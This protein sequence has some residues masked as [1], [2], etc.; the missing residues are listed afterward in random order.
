MMDMM[1]LNLLFEN[2][3]KLKRKKGFSRNFVGKLIRKWNEIFSTNNK[4]FLQTYIDLSLRPTVQY[5][6]TQKK[7]QMF[8]MLCVNLFYF[9]HGIHITVHIYLH[10][11]TL[12]LNIHM[13]VCMY[14]CMNVCTPTCNT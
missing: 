12:N 13:Y 6:S 14:V 4:Y 5:H 8:T 11:I 1:K 9:L 7:N 3:K 10:T 2:T